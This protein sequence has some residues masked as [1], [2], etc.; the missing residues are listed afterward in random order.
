MEAEIKQKATP[1]M[2]S[3]SFVFSYPTL[4]TVIP[5]HFIFLVRSKL[6]T[7]VV[8]K[9]VDSDTSLVPSVAQFLE[10]IDFTHFSVM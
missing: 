2:L 4:L 7:G 1:G 5:T 9:A 10:C 6:W 8:G 3:D